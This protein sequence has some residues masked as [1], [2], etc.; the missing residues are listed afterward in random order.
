MH[1]VMLHQLFYPHDNPREIVHGAPCQP[2]VD[3]LTADF[4]PF[5]FTS[6]CFSTLRVARP[7]KRGT[8]VE[9]LQRSMA[10]PMSVTEG[11]SAT[12]LEV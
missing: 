7:A 6:C 9:E 4:F 2:R 5:S 1:Q 12:V 11:I 3:S 8:C 10:A